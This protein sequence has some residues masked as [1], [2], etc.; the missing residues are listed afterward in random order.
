M[1]VDA[2]AVLLILL[3]P[4]NWF[5]ALLLA[6]ISR[7]YPH[8][9]S[10]KERAVAAVICA[11]VATLAGVLAWSRLGVI[12]VSGSLALVLIATGL[13]LVSVP[14]LYWLFLLVTGRWRVGGHG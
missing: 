5:V 4:F 10:L 8:I 7:K 1:I 13:I 9:L 2:L 6:Y 14:Q 11:I 3:I 12:D